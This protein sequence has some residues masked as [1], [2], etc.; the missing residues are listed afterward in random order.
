MGHRTWPARQPGP[1]CVDCDLSLPPDK[2][3][4]RLCNAMQAPGDEL[5]KANSERQPKG[6][7]GT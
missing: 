3:D 1:K 5:A 7:A 6:D 2:C 4:S